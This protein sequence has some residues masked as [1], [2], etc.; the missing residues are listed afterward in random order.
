MHI[1]R[2]A[3][4]GTAMLALLLAMALAPGV[5]GADENLAMADHPIVGTWVADDTPEDLTDPEM[6]SVFGP[7][8][9]L[10]NTR[11]DYGTTAGSWLPTGDRSADLTFYAGLIP[12]PDIGYIGFLIIRGDVVVSEDG[13]SFQ[14]TWTAQYPKVDPWGEVPDGQLGPIE[15]TGRR[16]NVEPMGTPVG[17]WPP[18]SPPE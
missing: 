7:G 3:L 17:P 15:V 14:G 11:P 4:A 6:L 13:Q 5:T 1:G 9:S 8:G 10:V 18:P 12:D 2:L 16:V